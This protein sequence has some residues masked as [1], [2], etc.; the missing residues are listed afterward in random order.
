MV[1]W[2]I[3]YKERRWVVQRYCSG[4]AC[5]TGCAVV[6]CTMLMVHVVHVVHEARCSDTVWQVCIHLVG[7]PIIDNEPNTLY[8]LHKNRTQQENSEE[9]AEKTKYKMKK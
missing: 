9:K 8:C 3:C 1:R 4:G 2:Y 5:N 6:Q 7:T